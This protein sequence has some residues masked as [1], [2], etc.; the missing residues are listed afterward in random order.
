MSDLPVARFDPRSPGFRA[1]PYPTYRYLR[2]HQPIHYRAERRDFILTRYA[3][4]REVLR[5]P[6]FGRSASSLIEPVAGTNGGLVERLVSARNE[7]RRLMGLWLALTNPPDHT[8]IRRS[9]SRAFTQSRIDGLRAYIQAKV[10]ASLDQ[11]ME[12]GEMDV[13]GELAYPLMLD[14]NCNRILGIPPGD[15]HP[16]FGP[17][18]QSMSLLADLDITPI[19]YERGMLA[20]A[21]LAEFFRQWIAA[22]RAGS[23][24]A[25]GLIG[26]LMA[27]GD[28]LS[29]EE[30]LANCIMMFTVGHSSTVNLIG[31]ALLSL[32]K[33]PAQWRLLAAEP[34]LIDR[35]IAE[36][37][38]YD[39]P[40]Q[41][42]SR[43]AFSD[44]ALSDR[45][46]RRGEKVICLIGAANRDPARFPEPD[47]FDIGRRPNPHLSFGYGIHTCIGKNLAQL[48]TKI[49]VGTVARRLP[50]LSLATDSPQWEE[51]FLGHGLKT[52]PVVF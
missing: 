3:D 28:R 11:A 17:W 37:L 34:S 27:A 9:L 42:I 45:T 4:N 32:L 44:V 26:M 24:P 23:R 13:I 8:R 39:S 48:A 43:T 31:I 21:G 50:G 36:I 18:T 19:A 40:V 25:D 20:I 30:R 1:N 10:D 2:T 49:V 33:H 29:E 52:L 51:S 41:G 35:A 14:L 16:N 12:R 5:N 7:S 15:W 22:C 47:R 46:I 38:R 6:G